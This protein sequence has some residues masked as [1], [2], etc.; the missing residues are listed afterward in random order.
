MD[1]D[2]KA[3]GIRSIQARP[4]SPNSE[5]E[6]VKDANRVV[7]YVAGVQWSLLGRGPFRTVSARSTASQAVATWTFDV[8]DRLALTTAQRA[9]L[10][11]C[12]R[13]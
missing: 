8:L 4:M 12:R 11:V 2:L 1:D 7:G 9:E 3:T 5:F 6:F 10:I 13:A